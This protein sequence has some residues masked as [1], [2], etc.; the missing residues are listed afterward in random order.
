MPAPYQIKRLILSQFQQFD[1]CDLD[2]THPDTGE[3][4]NEVCLLGPNG[5]GKSTI[6]S[7]IYHSIDSTLLP[8]STQ[9]GATDDS[10]ILTEFRIGDQSVY[11]A[12]SG[13]A[14]AYNLG[15][16][17]WFSPGIEQ[18]KRWAKLPE[19]PVSYRKFIRQ[20]SDH[21]LGKKEH[22]EL[23]DPALAF[24]SP[25]L[26]VID[27]AEAEN[28]YD[29]LY[30][31]RRQR[32]DLYHAFLKHD[33]NRERTVAEVEADFE[34]LTPNP[35]KAFKGLWN[36]VLGEMG[37]TFRPTKEPS[38]I[39]AHTGEEVSFY[40]L[41]PGLQSYLL[42]IALVFCQY[43]NQP[44]RRGF[45]FLDLPECGLSP[46]LAI[47]LV[48]FF[49][50]NQPEHPGQLFIATH[51]TEVAVQFEPQSLINLEFDEETGYVYH[52]RIEIEEEAAESEPEEEAEE[53]AETE[54]NKTEE[55]APATI[56]KRAAANRYSRLKR[57][58]QNL[59]DE[60]K[61]ADLVDEAFSI[62]KF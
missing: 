52:E 19:K 40:S 16:V 60:N 56:Q 27:S 38:L 47:S 41:S 18:T 58:I 54:N 6:L 45:V 61:L 9:P 25:Q 5:S 29:F 62:R 57:Q 20:F 23:P 28:F 8:S 13:A 37:I 32:Q 24:F 43:Y 55:D 53:I 17:S 34:A 44:E 51:E 12:R 59:E 14:D 48:Q 4:L 50:P 49:Q 21:K 33:E 3:V 7:Q 42:R 11:Q 31:R 35:L 36:S 10:L 2:F 22:P 1:F 39:S 15:E 46:E 26:A 30:N